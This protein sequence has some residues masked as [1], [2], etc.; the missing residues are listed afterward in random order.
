MLCEEMRKLNL[1][2]V[3]QGYLNTLVVESNLEHRIRCMQKYDSK[4]HKIKRYLGEGKYSE[5]HLD[6]QDGLFFNGHL[7]VPTIHNQDMRKVVMK[8][9]HETPLSIHPGSTKMYQDIR[10]R[11]WW[12]D[13]KRDIA[14]YV[15]ECD[16][17]RS[18]NGLLDFCNPL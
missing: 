1:H 7:V 5:F 3:P 11:Y 17:C 13:M 12:S 16:N 18:I 6:D 8:E 15:A 4:V 2:I 9:A 10:Q 14:Q